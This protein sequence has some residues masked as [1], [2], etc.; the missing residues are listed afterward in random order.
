MNFI[1]NKDVQLSAS[2]Y[3]L[4]FLAIVSV[5][6]A[7]CEYAN[8]NK[9]F[10]TSIIGLVG[11][12]L[13]LFISGYYYN[14]SPCFIKFIKRKIKTIII[15][16]ILWGVIT[17]L[18]VSIRSG[19]TSLVNLILWI[20]GYKTW[21]YYIPVLLVI[22]CLFWKRKSISFLLFMVIVNILSI[23]FTD[24]FDPN[25]I[26][27]YYQNPLNFVGFFAIGVLI[28]EKLSVLEEFYRK[29]NKKAYA[30]T[31]ISFLIIGFILYYHFCEVPTY[32]KISSYFFEVFVIIVLF[33]ILYLLKNCKKDDIIHRIFI[34]VG[35]NTY[36]IYF[37]H[38]QIGIG[39]SEIV[40]LKAHLMD[41]IIVVFVEPIIA[42]LVSFSICLILRF[43]ARIVKMDRFL[44][45]LGIK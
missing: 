44:W 42:I 36:I 39:V 40:C 34:S 29:K 7:H 20:L 14:D 24:L 5:V 6:F 37:I 2:M 43:M 17:Y 22:F 8:E 3:E 16:W 33:L 19:S 9:Q 13:F 23:L 4:R 38:M 26:I 11:V 35:K 1:E 31:L 12:P 25:L 15:P 28:K 45:I 27:T 18:S 10:L 21:L 41:T 32:F 30:Y